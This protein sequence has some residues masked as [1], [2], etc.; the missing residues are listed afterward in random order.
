[1]QKKGNRNINYFKDDINNL[2]NLKTNNYD[3]VF[4]FAI[5]H[6]ATEIDDALKKLSQCLK[7]DGLMFNEEYVGPARNQYS[8]EQLA[9][10][11][12]S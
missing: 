3:A 2:Q 8:D 12:R 9:T 7:P 4:N 5:L 1:M 10:H 6:H 11:A